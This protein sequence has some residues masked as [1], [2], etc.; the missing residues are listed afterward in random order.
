[1]IQAE[2]D[3]TWATLDALGAVKRPI[4]ED[5]LAR[6]IFQNKVRLWVSGHRD[7]FQQIVTWYVARELFAEPFRSLY[8]VQTR[9]F[10]VRAPDSLAFLAQSASHQKPSYCHSYQTACTISAL[11]GVSV[12]HMFLTCPAP[13]DRVAVAEHQLT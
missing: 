11:Y 6:N 9:P 1:V 8:A 2:I 3:S 10:R 4:L 13:A 12:D 5:Y 7:K